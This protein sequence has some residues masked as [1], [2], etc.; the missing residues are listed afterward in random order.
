[1]AMVYAWLDNSQ[2]YRGPLS[3]RV[4]GE[5]G[6]KFTDTISTETNGSVKVSF[7]PFTGSLSAS[8]DVQV[9]F[10]VW[11]PISSIRKTKSVGVVGK[12]LFM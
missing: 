11:N 5:N 10:V 6:E 3:Y 1:M 2:P 8:K 9:T 12:S 4:V 7:T